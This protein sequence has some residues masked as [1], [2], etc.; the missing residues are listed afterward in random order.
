MQQLTKGPA[1][2]QQSHGYNLTNNRR[3][4]FNGH[5]QFRKFQR[6][7]FKVYNDATVAAQQFQAQIDPAQLIVL[8]ITGGAAFYWWSILIPSERASLGRSKRLGPFKQYLTDLNIDE[9]RKLERWFYRDWLNQLDQGKLGKIR[10][11][12]DATEQTPHQ[13]QQEKINSVQDLK[14]V[15]IDKEPSFFSLD[16]PIV[17][18]FAVLIVIAIMSQLLQ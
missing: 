2:I 4:Q 12:M 16:N 1:S 5:R 15:Y 7:Q 13:Q 10:Q 17:V 3:I 18:T 8:G 14:D 9:S 6:H 11:N